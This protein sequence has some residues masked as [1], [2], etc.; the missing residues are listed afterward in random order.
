M[1]ASIKPLI[2]ASL[3]MLAVVVSCNLEKPSDTRTQFI[4]R[5][6]SYSAYDS[7]DVLDQKVNEV[8]CLGHSY[9]FD[10]IWEF[11]YYEKNLQRNAGFF[12]YDDSNTTIY[13]ASNF[14]QND[15]LKVVSINKN[16]LIL[17]KRAKTGKYYEYHKSSL[18]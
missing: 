3:A 10:G 5:W 6:D 17:D 4:G 8:S 7:L 18:K 12:T 1:K 16:M 13:L 11:F 14:K 9:K 15:T 2:I